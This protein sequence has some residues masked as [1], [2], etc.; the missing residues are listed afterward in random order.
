MSFTKPNTNQLLEIQRGGNYSLGKGNVY[1]KT[2]S[3]L[4]YSLFVLPLQKFMADVH[5]SEI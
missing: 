2:P 3:Y 1:D 5:I 4:S